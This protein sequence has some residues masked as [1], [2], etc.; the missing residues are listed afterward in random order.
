MLPYGTIIALFSRVRNEVRVWGSAAGVGAP[1]MP[2]P[3]PASYV[4]FFIT[5][6]DIL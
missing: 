6:C 2:G 1:A 3:A 5:F 4:S